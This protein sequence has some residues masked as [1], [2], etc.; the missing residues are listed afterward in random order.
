[1]W[2]TL[3]TYPWFRQALGRSMAGYL[4]FVWRTSRVVMEPVD[5]YDQ[6]ERELP[7]IMT[8]WH[9]QHFLTPFVTKP[10]HRAKVMISRSAD[11]DI[12]A[13][14][15]E[16]LGIGTVRGSGAAGRDFNR[17]GG[18]DATRQL[19]HA[20]ED[21]IN[22][23][24]TADVPKIARVVGLG[25][26][27][28]ARHSGR[29]VFPVAIATRHRILA[30]SWDRAAIHLPFG[31]AAVVAGPGVRVPHNADAAALEEA[32]REVQRQLE[33]ATARAEALVGRG[34]G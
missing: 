32:R 4:R 34:H 27:A 10:H 20:L 22:V 6:A 3:R 23:A 1:M 31:R 28:V 12:N 16:A 17:K 25:V 24:M 13:I 29:P 19:V 14:A 18:V 21:G 7:L 30:K 11:A 5:I 9:G 2:R 15:A 8:F 26:I 33:V